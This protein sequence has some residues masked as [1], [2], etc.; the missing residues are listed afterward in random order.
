V[1]MNAFWWTGDRVL[2]RRGFASPEALAASVDVGKPV[3][4]W[5]EFPSSWPFDERPYWFRFWAALL[6]RTGELPPAVILD[7]ELPMGRYWEIRGG[8]WEET[9]RLRAEALGGPITL[10]AVQ[11]FE[12]RALL[13]AAAHLER[14][15]PLTDTLIFNYGFCDI[16]DVRLENHPGGYYHHNSPF[17]T[18]DSPVMYLDNRGGTYD[19]LRKHPRWNRM[20]TA[21][22]LLL[23]CRRR[24]VPWVAP[25][26][27]G[28][29]APTPG[30]G[31]SGN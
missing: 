1:S 22:R 10:E 26:G 16:G 25:P 12:D 24:V 9:Q 21:L 5:K 14:H 11:A 30:P 7:W 17:G 23:A 15:F 31:P 28:D 2:D 3:R 4:L 8:D 13:Q 19:N 27:Y 20:I 6:E 29:T 18:A